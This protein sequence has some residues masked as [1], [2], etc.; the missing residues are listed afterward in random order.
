MI[1]ALLWTI[2]ESGNICLI[3]T[4]GPFPG[5]IIVCIFL[6]PST[7]AL[8]MLNR[9]CFGVGKGHSNHEIR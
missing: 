8:A 4:S 1:R 7:Q 6:Q 2:A 3:C 5:R 9:D